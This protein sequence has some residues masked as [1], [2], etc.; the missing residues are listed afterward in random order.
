MLI[1]IEFVLRIYPDLSGYLIGRVKRGNVIGNVPQDYRP[2][3]ETHRA[4]IS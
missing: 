3:M 1:K 4:E 2:G